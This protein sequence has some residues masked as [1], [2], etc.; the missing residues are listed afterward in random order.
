M[1][2]QLLRWLDRQTFHDRALKLTAEVFYDS[3]FLGN[4]QLQICRVPTCKINRAGHA[5]RITDGK[6]VWVKDKC[7]IE[8]LYMPFL[9]TDDVHAEMPQFL[10]IQVNGLA[11]RIYLILIQE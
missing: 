10:K 8:W 3:L 6:P 7:V 4:G 9:I 11:V 1:N 2:L 5:I